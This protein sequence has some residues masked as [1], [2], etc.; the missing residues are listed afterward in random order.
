[1]EHLEHVEDD[2]IQDVDFARE[3]NYYLE[4]FCETQNP[5]IEDLRE[6]PQAVFNACMMYVGH[7]AFKGTSKLKLDRPLAGYGDANG[8]RGISRSNCNAYDIDKIDAICD[9]YIYLCG[10]Y[11]K[12]ISILGFSKL[13]AINPDSIYDWANGINKLNTAGSEIYKKLTKEREE[14]IVSRLA[15]SKQAVAHIAMINHY[16]DGWSNPAT[17]LEDKKRIQTADQLPRFDDQKELNVIE[18]QDVV[19]GG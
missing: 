4:E 6:A 3:I 8:Y 13:A 16:G 5:P 1:M 14:S 11:N 12:V 18:A 2:P 19:D 15:D 7:H 17:G 9:I 10:V